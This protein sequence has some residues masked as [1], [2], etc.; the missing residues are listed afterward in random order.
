MCRIDSGLE[1]CYTIDGPA[2]GTPLLLVAGLGLDLTS[3]HPS[4]VNALA[5]AGLRVIRLDNRD[6]GRSTHIDARP[7]SFFR[8]LFG[9]VA[10]RDYTLD[11][12]AGD[13]VG[14]LEHLKIERAHVVGMSMGGMIAQVLAATHPERVCSLI[15]IISNTGARGAGKPALSTIARLAVPPRHDVGGYVEH[16]VRM[17]RHIGSRV[18]PVDTS[19]ERAWAAAAWRREHDAGWARL[20][21]SASA[22]QI[23]AIN[24]SGDRTQRL[25]AIRVPTLVIHGDRDLMVAPS[26]GRATAAAIAGARFVEIAGLRHHLPESV[27]PLLSRLIVEH[28]RGAQS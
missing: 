14:L 23:A 3:W 8:M 20:A 4:L 26:G 7:P 27:T 24:K 10:A 11:D 5:A 17:I 22:R 28:V 15:S 19:Y 13:V 12:M 16:H 9:I 1:L 2:G 21:S 6:V 18:F 25:A